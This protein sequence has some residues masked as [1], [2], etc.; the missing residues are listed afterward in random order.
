VEERLTHRAHA[1]VFVGSNPTDATKNSIYNIKL[2]GR[3]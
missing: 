1:P 2:G 3:V